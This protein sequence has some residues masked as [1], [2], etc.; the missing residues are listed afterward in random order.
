MT[1][2]IPSVSPSSGLSEYG[3]AIG[4]GLL[5]G[6]KQDA[7]A[8]AGLLYAAGR[9]GTP[10]GTISLVMGAAALS[11]GVRHLVTDVLYAATDKLFNVSTDASRARRAGFTRTWQSMSGPERAGKVSEFAGGFLA[12]GALGK[13]AT[14]GARAFS[15]A[16]QM[17]TFGVFGRRGS[18]T[19]PNRMSYLRN[20]HGH[21]S[22]EERIVR[23]DELSRQNYMRRLTD[24]LS[25]RDYVFRYLSEQSF[26]SALTNG[27]VKGY[28]TTFFSHSSNS[29]AKSAQIMPKWG[30]ASVWYC[31]TSRKYFSYQIGKATWRHCKV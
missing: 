6:V 29:V 5:R 15:R 14:T 28:A 23:I 26:K 10:E 19:F 22:R 13:A 11:Q 16:G 8:M 2:D 20:K 24:N 7:E 21:L 1:F 4:A 27:N 3:K 9:S 31:Y 25:Q 12:G 17:N 30:E 18:Q